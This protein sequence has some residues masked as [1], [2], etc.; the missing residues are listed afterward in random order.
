MTELILRSLRTR[1]L[2][3][4]HLNTRDPRPVSSL[5]RLDPTNVWLGV[6][7]T[8]GLV[9][10]LA[11]HPGAA[12]YVPISQNRWG[13]LRDAVFLVAARL[14]RRSRIVHL[15]G[16]HFAAFRDTSGPL[17]RAVMRAA[18]SG[19]DQAWILSNGL[20]EMFGDLIPQQRV[21][22]LENAVDDPRGS[23]PRAERAPG[24]PLRL[25]YLSNLVPEK[26]CFE[27]IEAIEQASRLDGLPALDLRLI[28]EVT[29]EVRHRIEE[30]ARRLASHGITVE[31][32]GPK[33]GAAKDE[34]YARADLF[35]Y[36]T[37]YPYEGQP[38]VLLEAMGA[39]LPIIT[40]SLAAIPE[41]V[42]DGSSALVVPPGDIGRLAEAL[43]GAASDSKLRHRLGIAARERYL[44]RYTPSRFDEELARL[45]SA[46]VGE[47]APTVH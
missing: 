38:L 1:H 12:V 18:L 36:P 28:G 23:E 15:N 16:G 42:E 44:A 3:A 8:I 6:K 24:E 7:H 13:F 29:N 43:M 31:V 21:H 39:G 2:L 4:A 46:D 10:V 40:T 27:L 25:L 37:R 32:L 41:T 33:T 45:L 22:V 26:G 34:E 30:R 17:V 35:A 14:A 20:R 9:A 47:R 19:V 11:R 5:G